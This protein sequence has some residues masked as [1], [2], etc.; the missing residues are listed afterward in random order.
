MKK[1][2]GA[3][4]IL[5]SIFFVSCSHG[6]DSSGGSSNENSED[7]NYDNKGKKHFL[8]LTNDSTSDIP[9]ENIPS[10]RSARSA[11]SSRTEIAEPVP[12]Q[13]DIQL[14]DVNL[15]ETYLLDILKIAEKNP[16]TNRSFIN[17]YTTTVVEPQIGDTKTFWCLDG[18]NSLNDN[19]KHQ[20]TFVLKAI[21]PKCLIWVSTGSTNHPEPSIENSHFTSLAENLNQVFEHEMAIYGSN[22]QTLY[23]DDLVTADANTKLNVLIYDI[24]GDGEPTQGSAIV[25]GLFS[26]ADMFLQTSENLPSNIK[27][28]QCECIHADSYLLK[29][30]ITRNTKY[31]T[32]TLLHEFQHML[33]FINK[34]VKNGTISDTWYNE[35][36]SMCAEDIFQTQLGLRDEDSPKSRLPQFNVVYYDGFKIWRSGNDVLK[37]YANSYAFGAYLMRNYGGVNLIH[38][39]ASNALVNESSITSALQACGYNETFNSVL[40]KFVDVIVYPAD[41]SKRSLNKSVNQTFGNVNYTLT[42]IN[43]LNYGSTTQESVLSYIYDSENRKSTTSDGQLIIRGPIILNEG[44]YYQGGSLGAYGTHG[45]YLGIKNSKPSYASTSGVTQTILCMD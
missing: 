26:N 42:A 35:M 13:N 25:G 41:S 21:Q 22:V 30:D 37:S 7:A 29:R 9:F 11:V 32:S 10:S 19:T 38:Q 5:L 44:A 24:C 14:I 31:I 4:F 2:L 28:N 1:T 40:L 17:N 16:Q 3:I 6:N 36:L 8:L 45:I 27:S 39:I 15:D 34:T 20:Y 43:L 12:V 23:S 33:H 18:S